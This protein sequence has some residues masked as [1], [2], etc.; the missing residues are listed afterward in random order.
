MPTSWL[1]VIVPILIYLSER[2]IRLLRGLR[3]RRIAYYTL[4]P[5]NVLEIAIENSKSNKINYETGQ[6]IYLKV[7]S[8]S[9]F[10]WHPF[11]I[12]S[13]PDDENLTVHIRAE[14]DWTKKLMEM[15]QKKDDTSKETKKSPAL[16]RISVD[17]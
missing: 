10:E 2:L 15:I 12:T 3:P 1:Y 11:T 8:L 4:H 16:D 14:G 13:A 6:Y 17:G 9:L 5:S 7:K